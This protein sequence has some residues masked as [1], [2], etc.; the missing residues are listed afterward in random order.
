MELR[1]RKQIRLQNHDYSRAGYYF[2]TICVKDRWPILCRDAQCL[3]GS[4]RLP[5]SEQ[6]V[7]VENGIRQIPRR[8]SGVWVDRY[9]IMPNHIHMILVLAEED[10]RTMNTPVHKASVSIAV[11]MLK[12]YVT[13]TLTYS[14]W[15][16]SFHDHIIRD[17]A[18]Y[19]R[20][21][22]YIETNPAKWQEDIYYAVPKGEMLL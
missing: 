4:S 5:L 9:V 22:E 1:Q 7:L 20:I 14:I 12:E 19:L 15:Q 6:G 16:K 17:E 8:Y 13:K 10:G 18:E 3:P 21:C 11:R 2:V